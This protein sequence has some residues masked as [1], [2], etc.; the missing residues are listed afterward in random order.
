MSGIFLTGTDTDIGKT[1][2]TT[3]LVHFFQKRNIP[4]FSYKPIQTGAIWQNGEWKAPDPEVY[5][6]VVKPSSHQEF[7]G[8]LFQKA[9]SPHLAARH[10]GTSINVDEIKEKIALAERKYKHVIVEGAG[11]LFVPITDNGYCMIDLMQD[12]SYPVILVARAGLGTI[13]HTVLSVEALKNRNIPIAGI[14]FNQLSVED[15][16]IEEDN[17][18][19]VQKLTNVP[20]IGSVPYTDHLNERLKEEKER[21]PLVSNWDE[22]RLKGVLLHDAGTVS[23]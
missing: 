5:E 9:S 13:N 22:E 7:Y 17:R 14:I 6:N 19:M 4:L 10:E 21:D 23:K 8:L 1:V 18:A 16:E 20:V 3:L 11:G 15:H 12:L 2:V